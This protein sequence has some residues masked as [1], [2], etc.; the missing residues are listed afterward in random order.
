[1][2]EKRATSAYHLRFSQRY[3]YEPLPQ[4]LRQVWFHLTMGHQSIRT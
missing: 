2:A 1:M 4:P 3:G